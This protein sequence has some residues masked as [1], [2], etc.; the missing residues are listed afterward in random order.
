MVL[1]TSLLW[2]LPINTR[3]LWPISVYFG[4]SGCG[5][6]PD[7]AHID[8][9]II[10]RIS[11]QFYWRFQTTTCCRGL[12]V[13]HSRWNFMFGADIRWTELSD[14]AWPWVGNVKVVRGKATE[15][16][17]KNPKDG[18]RRRNTANN[19]VIM[20]NLSTLVDKIYTSAERHIYLVTGS[21]NYWMSSGGFRHLLFVGRLST[22]FN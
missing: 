10:R 17:F 14:L 6:L 3:L 12:P 21:C 4:C 9:E 5:P 11:C 7:D 22:V 20:K 13:V 19:V 18:K 1:Y 8:T 15:G 16:P 2:S